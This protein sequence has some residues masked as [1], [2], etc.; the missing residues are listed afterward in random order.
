MDEAELREQIAAG[1]SERLEWLAD[2][3]SIEEIAETLVAL[4]NTGGGVLVLGLEASGAVAGVRHPEDAID[5][6]LEAALAISPALLLPLPRTLR[7]DDKTLVLA[8][9]P[10]GMP[11]VYAYRGRYLRRAR[12]SNEPLHPRELRRLMIERGEWSFESEAAPGASM[13]D[14]DWEQA[15]SYAQA[16]RG[17][18]LH[19]TETILLRRGCLRSVDGRL[20]P[21]HAGILLFGKEPQAFVRGA[22]VSAVRFA[23]TKMTD[24]FSRQDIG[25]TLI[26]QIRR[27]E[28]FLHDHLRKHVEL[29]GSMARRESYEVPME[30]ARELV[31]NAIAHRD[32]SIH[33]DTIRL[34]IFSDRL[35]V[36]SPGALPGP[37]TVANLKEERFSRNPILV[38]VLAD[39][40]FI[41]RLGYGVDRVMELMA[42]QNLQQPVFEER[43]GGFRV[44]LQSQARSEV[45]VPEQKSVEDFDLMQTYSGLAMNPRQQAALAV[46]HREDHGRI[47]NGELQGLFPEVH[48]E[49][50]RRD[51]ADLVT[52]EILVKLG[53]K[54]GSYYVLKARQEAQPSA[55]KA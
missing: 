44:V 13:A 32:Y 23:G 49:T 37:M 5:Y 12:S 28:T 39:L 47:T 2:R 15:R 20:Q 33:G 1:R 36:H 42:A 54:R 31:V 43:A 35:E 38:Q 29:T 52:K 45:P 10:P 14:L 24:Q 27:C 6:I 3:A 19:D 11:G 41:E 34:L 25:G 7:L 21:T 18:S 48:P 9:I 40:R 30:A 51:L 26:D 8:Q 50:I 55:E 17:H 46:L 4:A 16:L 22:E 53:Q